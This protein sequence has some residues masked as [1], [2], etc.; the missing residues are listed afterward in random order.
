VV[1]SRLLA[2]CLSGALFLTVGCSR[3]RGAPEP[4]TEDQKT[5]YTLGVMVG[6]SIGVFNLSPEELELVKA[7]LTDSVNKKKPVV[8]TET[9]EPKVNELARTR[10]VG[11]ANAEKARAKSVIEAAAREPGA[12]KLPSGMVIRTTKPG[13]G[14]SP[15]ASDQVKVHY[16][17]TLTDGTVFDSS[18]KR[19]EPATFPLGG[20]IKCWTEGVQKMKVGEKALL[21]CPSELAYG[22]QGRP[23]TIPGGATLI[24]D[25]ELLEILPKPGGAPGMS[26]APPAGH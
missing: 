23:P 5:V 1:P 8:A 3:L 11:A 26:G 25:V 13:S 12:V 19:K 24:F 6:R 20:V 17:G 21:T 10:S 14:P 22:D 4:K 16:Q 7:G 9:Y 18:I 15:E 2:C